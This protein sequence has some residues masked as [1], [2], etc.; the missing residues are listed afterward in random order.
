MANVLTFYLNEV[1]P[2][3]RFHFQY[4]KS[5]VSVTNISSGWIN[6]GCTCYSCWR[7]LALLLARADDITD[8]QSE[9]SNV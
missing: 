1:Q 8:R 9:S 5:T 4:K 2:G 3:G 6:S 7:Y